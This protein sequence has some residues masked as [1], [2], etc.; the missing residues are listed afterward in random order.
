MD[1]KHYK[2]T[3]ALRTNDATYF[4]TYLSY[5]LWFFNGYFPEKQNLEIDFF[6]IYKGEINSRKS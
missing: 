3:I 1:L 5:T 4:I 6:Q 2:C